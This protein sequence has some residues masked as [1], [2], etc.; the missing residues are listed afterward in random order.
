MNSM[1]Q[2]DGAAIEAV[3]AGETGLLVPPA[4][5]AALATAIRLV[6][7]DPVFAQRLASA[8]RLRVEQEFSSAAMLRQVTAVYAELLARHGVSHD[9]G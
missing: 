1:G 4:D 7:S 9:P 3:L 8:G 6:L 5:P 2:N